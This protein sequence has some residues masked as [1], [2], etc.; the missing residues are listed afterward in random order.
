MKQTIGITYLSKYRKTK[1]TTNKIHANIVIESMPLSSP[2]LTDLR[3]VKPKIIPS[4]RTG[5][6]K[7]HPIIKATT[8]VKIIPNF[9]IIL[10]T[11]KVFLTRLVFHHAQNN[12]SI[13]LRV[14]S[15]GFRKCIPNQAFVGLYDKHPSLC[16]RHYL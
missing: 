4:H 2:I 15:L 6:R 1:P 3:N 9:F 7:I 13:L 8:S 12:Y 16:F 10:F 5:P 11:Q 14:E